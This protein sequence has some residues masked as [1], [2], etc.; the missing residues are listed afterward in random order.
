M[1]RVRRFAL[2]FS[3]FGLGVV[4][5]MFFLGGKNASCAYGPNARV[6]KNIRIKNPEIS[7]E[8]RQ[9]LQNFSLD[10]T[11]ISSFLSSGKVLFRDSNIQIND[12]CKKYVIKGK[13]AQ[14]ELY[15]MQ[16][17]NCDSTAFITSFT[18]FIDD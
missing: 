18:R 3:G 10:S 5:L 11:V 12:S 9:Q 4:L 15:L 14:K 17:K 1:T 16:V 2:Y 8:I 13:S 7:P 6:L